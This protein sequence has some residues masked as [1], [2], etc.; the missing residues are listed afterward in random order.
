MNKAIRVVRIYISE[1][2]HGPNGNLKDFIFRRLREEHQ[3]HGLTIFRGIAGFGSSG[4]VH[5]ADL[6][7]LR[8]D[9]PVVIEFF[10]TPERVAV[11]LDALEGLIPPGHLIIWDATCNC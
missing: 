11:A 8:A 5:A 9:L 4:E 6:L 7:T 2:D 10:D 3:V 1:T